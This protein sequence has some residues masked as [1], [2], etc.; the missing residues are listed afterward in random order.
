MAL[1][2]SERFRTFVNRGVLYYSVRNRKRKA[3]NISTWMKDHDCRTVLLVGVLGDEYTGS[4]IASADI[5][6]RRLLSEFDVK[7]GINIVEANTSYPFM[8]ADAREL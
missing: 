2:L 8:V 5:V 7:M 6:E 1:S 4:D 3:Q